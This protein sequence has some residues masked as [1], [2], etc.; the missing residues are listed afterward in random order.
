MKNRI[1]FNSC[2]VD[3]CLAVNM[4]TKF[5]KEK[6]PSNHFEMVP[7]TK[8][9]THHLPTT[10][11][12]YT[13]IVGAQLDSHTILAEK[14][15]SSIIVFFNYGNH[16]YSD[17][18]LSL[19]YNASIEIY[20]P[21]FHSG[22]HH[23]EVETILDN[24]LCKLVSLYLKHQ[25]YHDIYADPENNF[26]EIALIQA[27][28]NYVNFAK[29]LTEQELIYLYSNYEQIIYCAVNARIFKLQ[30]KLSDNNFKLLSQGDVET[31]EVLKLHDFSRVQTARSIIQ[32]NL[33]NTLH[34][35][36]ARSI[37]LPTASVA[38][39]HVFDVIRLMSYPYPTVVT[40]EDVKYW[41]IW[42]IYSKDTQ[43]VKD[44]VSLIDHTMKW[45]ENKV[46]YLM[47]N[48]PGVK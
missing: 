38:E 1:V 21:A 19:L 17:E 6:Y 47:S 20:T 30:N 9:E 32:R 35:T 27:V 42:R 23:T 7:F 5:L 43:Q 33:S 22:E 11:S 26:E 25:F 37:I 2:N 39:E 44:A 4:L 48:L 29:T 31:V 10:K 28:M 16:D 46:T 41:R 18:Q 3:S 8:F 45:T 12:H 40:F 15:Q 14:E 36:Q 34:G 24:S 13:F